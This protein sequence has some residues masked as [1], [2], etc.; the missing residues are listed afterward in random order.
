MTETSLPD[1]SIAVNEHDSI[2]FNCTVEGYPRPTVTWKNDGVPMTTNI[3]ETSA[4]NATGVWVVTSEINLYLA[5]EHAGVIGC[6]AT[7]GIGAES[8]ATT[9]LLMTCKYNLVCHFTFS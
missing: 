5:R 2:T 6:F 1:P 8:S 7:N 4:S 3:T 9:S